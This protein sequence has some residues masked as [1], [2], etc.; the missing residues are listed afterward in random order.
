MVAERI[1]EYENATSIQ[2]CAKLDSPMERE[3]D[4]SI[5]LC[6]TINGTTTGII[7]SI[8]HENGKK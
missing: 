7:M 5:S 6:V 8:L 2:V 1:N 3:R 4:V